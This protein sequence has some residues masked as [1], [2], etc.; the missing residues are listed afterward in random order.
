M[1]TVTLN[2]LDLEREPDIVMNKPSLVLP[3]SR[4][5]LNSRPVHR[6]ARQ[7][8]TFHPRLLIT[9]SDSLERLHQPHGRV[10]CFRQAELFCHIPKIRRY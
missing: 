9:A 2:Q 10:R 6:A 7:R 5:Q 1:L 8:E 3:S 4:R